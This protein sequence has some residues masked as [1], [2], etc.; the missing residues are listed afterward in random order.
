MNIGQSKVIGAVL[1]TTWLA[2]IRLTCLVALMRFENARVIME[3]R[4]MSGSLPVFQF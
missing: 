2:V 4:A 3:L 1:K